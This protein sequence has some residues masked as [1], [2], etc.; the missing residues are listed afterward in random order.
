MSELV[1]KIH[2]LS[3]T[4]SELRLSTLVERAR[5]VDEVD[6]SEELAFCLA[7]LLPAATGDNALM[8]RRVLTNH[9]KR[10]TADEEL[11]EL[12]IDGDE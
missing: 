9:D 2:R 4:I 12:T 8:A 5:Y 3:Q 10:R 6:H 7:A 11:P 1:N